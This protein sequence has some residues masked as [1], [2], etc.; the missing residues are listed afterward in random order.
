MGCPSGPHSSVSSPTSLP[1]PGAD[2]SQPCPQQ[3]PGLTVQEV[4]VRVRTQGWSG[5]PTP[6]D[7]GF[8]PQEVGIEARVQL[9][10]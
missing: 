7:H 4:L 9:P 5:T 8:T 10:S 2:P 3:N 6:E 1:V